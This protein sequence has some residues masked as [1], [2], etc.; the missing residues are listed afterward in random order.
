MTVTGANLTLYKKVNAIFR[1][2][3]KEAKP[4]NFEKLTAEINPCSNHKKVWSG[5]KMLTDSYSQ[6]H[7]NSISRLPKI[8]PRLGLCILARKTLLQLLQQSCS[9]HQ[10][11]SSAKIIEPE[12][13]Y[14]ENESTISSLS[15]E[16]PGH[17]KISYDMLKYLLGLN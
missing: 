14:P 6:N 15:G 2:K 4:M 11:N 17:D 5:I 13:T 10:P 12:D 16:T 1:K 3:F 8:L 9:Y 7:I